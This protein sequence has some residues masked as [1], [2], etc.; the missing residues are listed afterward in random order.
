MKD[1]IKYVKDIQIVKSDKEPGL[2]QIK[3]KGIAYISELVVPVLVPGKN[4]T[5]ADDGIY[6]LE[7]KFDSPGTEGMIVEIEIKTEL[8]IKNLPDN[9]KAIKIKAS[10]NADIELIE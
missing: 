10:D 6:E 1:K 9:I 3:A 4:E 2:I 8:R 7:F 5:I